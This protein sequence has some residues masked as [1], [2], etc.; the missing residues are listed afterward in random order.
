[1]EHVGFAGMLQ[2]SKV[3]RHGLG[4]KLGSTYLKPD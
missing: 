2:G 1:M 4:C 3:P